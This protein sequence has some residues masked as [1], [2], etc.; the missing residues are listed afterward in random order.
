MLCRDSDGTAAKGRFCTKDATLLILIVTQKHPG[1]EPDN[2]VTDHLKTIK[3]GSAKMKRLHTLKVLKSA[4]LTKEPDGITK[5]IRQNVVL[6][7]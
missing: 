2:T 3:P 1:T 4:F 7:Q 5:A 6:Y